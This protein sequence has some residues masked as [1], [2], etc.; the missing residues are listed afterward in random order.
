MGSAAVSCCS[1]N[2]QWEAPEKAKRLDL[3]RLFL[4]F[5]A[6]GLQFGVQA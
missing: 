1:R 3:L 4:E 6:Y 5:R 2:A